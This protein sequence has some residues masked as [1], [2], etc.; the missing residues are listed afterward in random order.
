MLYDSSK[1]LFKFQQIESDA[2]SDNIDGMLMAYAR[3]QQMKC[4]PAVFIDDSM[5]CVGTAL[6]ANHDVRLGCKHISDLALA[7]VTPVS[8]DYSFNQS[9]SSPIY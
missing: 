5:S 6:K 7:L 4:K 8:S 3:R 9:R 1:L 2:V